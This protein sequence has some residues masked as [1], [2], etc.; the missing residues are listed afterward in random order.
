MRIFSSFGYAL[1]SDHGLFAC[2]LRL[3]CIDL[4]HQI[5][6]SIFEIPVPQTNSQGQSG[7]PCEFDADLW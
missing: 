4:D 1:L 5:E 3:H 7:L 6:D 2:F